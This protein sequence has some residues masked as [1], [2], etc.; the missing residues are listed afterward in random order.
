VPQPWP[1][2]RREAR[3]ALIGVAAAGALALAVRVAAPAPQA[4]PFLG[5][6]QDRRKLLRQLLFGTRSSRLCIHSNNTPSFP[7]RVFLRPGFVSFASRPRI[8]G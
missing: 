2:L 1:A 3:P 5:F 6:A 8:E 7:R 4:Q